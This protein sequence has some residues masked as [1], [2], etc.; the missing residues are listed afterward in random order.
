LAEWIGAGRLE[1]RALAGLL[2]SLCDCLRKIHASGLAHVDL[3]P[4]NVRI[5]RDGEVEIDSFP[6]PPPN[7]TLIIAEPKYTA[8]ELLVAQAGADDVAH[9]R[10]DAY[11]VALLAYEA[12]AGPAALHAQIFEHPADAETDLL[13]MRWHADSTRRL[14][15]LSELAPQMPAEQCEFLV[16]GFQKLLSLLRMGRM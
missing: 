11:V 15:A 7:A 8:P 3:T 14:R 13:W 4:R 10:C 16:F 1:L 2:L 9:L 12:I 6:A 5:G